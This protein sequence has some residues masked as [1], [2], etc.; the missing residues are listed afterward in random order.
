MGC[1]IGNE[2][3]QKVTKRDTRLALFWL[4]SA[5]FEPTRGG[6][7]GENARRKGELRAKARGF[8]LK[9]EG[10]SVEGRP[11]P[12]KKTQQSHHLR[13]VSAAWACRRDPIDPVN[14]QKGVSPS[15]PRNTRRL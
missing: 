6:K 5:I 12:R 14:P 1:S 8:W 11:R 2:K 3:H 10:F 7:K 9:T 4:I 13:S 15:G